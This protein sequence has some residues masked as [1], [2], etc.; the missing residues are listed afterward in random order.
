MLSSFY[1]VICNRNTSD[2]MGIYGDLNVFQLF[3]SKKNLFIFGFFPMIWESEVVSKTP[4]AV[5]SF[6]FKSTAFFILE[7]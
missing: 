2:W 7:L 5:P 6:V 4:H 3:S 1:Y